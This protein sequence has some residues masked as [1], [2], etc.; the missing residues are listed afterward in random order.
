MKKILFCLTKPLRVLLG[1]KFIA[2][3]TI[4]TLLIPG[5][6]LFLGLPFLMI[7]FCLICK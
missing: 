6:G 2:L 4:P 3:G 1:L 7:G 5:F